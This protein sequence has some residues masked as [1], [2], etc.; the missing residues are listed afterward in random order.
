MRLSATMMDWMKSN[1]VG[2]ERKELMIEK[3]EHSIER[4]IQYL[5]KLA[6]RMGQIKRGQLTYLLV[7]IKRIY[8]IERFLAGVN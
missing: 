2:F 1:D 8:N 7:T 6:H 3:A 4:E 5:V